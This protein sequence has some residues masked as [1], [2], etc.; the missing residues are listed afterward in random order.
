MFFLVLSVCTDGILNIAFC[1]MG[2]VTVFLLIMTFLKQKIRMVFSVLRVLSVRLTHIITG[3]SS[4][5]G[6]RMS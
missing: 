5:A 2:I 3:S 1:R 6:R 4:F